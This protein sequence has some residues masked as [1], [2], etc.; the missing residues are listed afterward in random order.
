MSSWESE[1]ELKQE[2]SVVL[3]FERSQEAPLKR[4]GNGKKTRIEGRWKTNKLEMIISWAKCDLDELSTW[5][6]N[7]GLYWLWYEWRSRRIKQQPTR[8]RGNRWKISEEDIFKMSRNSC[9]WWRKIR[10][11]EETLVMSWKVRRVST[12]LLCHPK[13]FDEASRITRWTTLE[14]EW[15]RYSNEWNKSPMMIV[16]S[17]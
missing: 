9:R 8:E 13:K 12:A 3:R 16:V 2:L 17:L 4:P 14:L 6:Q 1:A 11:S 5:R 10:V 7:G 15:K